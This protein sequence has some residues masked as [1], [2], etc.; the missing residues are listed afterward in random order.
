MEP[1]SGTPL[2]TGRSTSTRKP[3]LEPLDLSNPA[4]VPERA[5]LSGAHNMHYNPA[6]GSK[7]D[8]KLHE[9]AALK[10]AQEL[11]RIASES[12]LSGARDGDQ[13]GATG[14][15]WGDAAAPVVGAMEAEEVDEWEDCQEEDKELAPSVA[16]F[17]AMALTLS[18]DT[19]GEEGAAGTQDAPPPQPAE[20]PPPAAALPMPTL[21]A[22]LRLPMPAQPLQL[23]QA[24]ISPLPQMG[25]RELLAELQGMED[26]L[27]E[28][29]DIA[30]RKVRSG[31]IAAA[32][33]A[34][35]RLRAAMAYLEP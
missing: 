7:T 33:E 30:M 23:P 35:A 13:R 9:D 17:F 6:H 21:G 19:A 26:E 29:M 12:A 32:N 22:G 31:D 8:L 20:T 11:E 2:G 10:K 16:N 1:S 4:G 3:L 28:Y 27:A 25:S 5:G 15:G 18:S 24:V 14:S 34:V